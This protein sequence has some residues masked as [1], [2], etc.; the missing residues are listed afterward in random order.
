MHALR[1]FYVKYTSNLYLSFKC[2]ASI[3]RTASA[4]DLQCSGPG[5]HVEEIVFRN[6]AAVPIIEVSFRFG[7]M[8][9]LLYFHRYG[10]LY[11]H[12]AGARRFPPVIGFVDRKACSCAQLLVNPY[13]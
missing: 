12:A 2:V 10:E 6:Q 11:I 5:L 3:R 4:K 9:V 1:S 13:I 7:R 8:R